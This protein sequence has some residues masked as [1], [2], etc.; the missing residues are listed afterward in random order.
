[1][2]YTDKDKEL[3]SLL[4][5]TDFKHPS[6][7]DMLRIYSKVEQ[8][9]PEALSQVLEQYPQLVGLIQ[10]SLAEYRD[11][12]DAVI[13]SDDESVRQFYEAAERSEGSSAESERRFYEV[14]ESVRSDYSKFLD[15]EGM[16]P[17]ER[18]RI[19]E[20]E[21]RIA[22]MA[23]EEHEAARAERTERLRAVSAK[24]SEKREFNWKLVGAASSVLLVAVGIGASILGGNIEF[25]LP[26]K[27]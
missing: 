4:G 1:M 20:K 5:R 3:L 21:E 10:S 26:K 15:A 7:G 6:K 23:K 13:R 8:M 27:P 12:L 2:E 19:L 11:T 24:D 25:R 16:T 14:L 22:Q 9:R 18:G 17:E